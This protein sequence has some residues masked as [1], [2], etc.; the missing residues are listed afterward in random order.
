LTSLSITVILSFYNITF[1]LST[2]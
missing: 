2:P 1:R